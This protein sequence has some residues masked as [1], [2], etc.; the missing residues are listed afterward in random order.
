MK[1]IITVLIIAVV[2][3]LSI[4]DIKRIRGMEETIKK[5]EETASPIMEDSR[6]PTPE[7][8]RKY[9]QMQEKAKEIAGNYVYR[10]QWYL[11]NKT[12]HS[13]TIV[14]NEGV[15]IFLA[16]PGGVYGRYY[17]SLKQGENVVFYYRP[18]AVLNAPS[19]FLMPL[20]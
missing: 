12:A 4:K 20:Q 14:G 10:K 2:V 6:T 18:D 5:W 1:K 17:E 9:L 11:K 7:D 15:D 8:L 19:E 16:I 13:I 3:L